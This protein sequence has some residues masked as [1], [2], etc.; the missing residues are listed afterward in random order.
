[1][2]DATDAERRKQRAE[3]LRAEID[4][5]RS[6]ADDSAPESAREFTDRAAHEASERN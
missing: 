2:Q 4:E 6:G 3:E 1:M 5:L